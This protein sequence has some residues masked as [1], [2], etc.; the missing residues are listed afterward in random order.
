V[1][2]PSNDESSGPWAALRYKFWT[3]ERSI[4][5]KGRLEQ[6]FQDDERLQVMKRALTESAVLCAGAL[7]I[8][9]QS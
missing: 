8:V 5:E 2:L 6:S 9:C 3:L 7:R 1:T 4:Q